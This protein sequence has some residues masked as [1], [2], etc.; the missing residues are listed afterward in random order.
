MW[1]IILND[2]ET[3]TSVEGSRALYVPKKYTGDTMDQFV[4]DNYSRAIDLAM[5]ETVLSPLSG[6]IYV[7][8]LVAHESE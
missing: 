2:G 4:K 5:T 6:D 3:Y 7:R 8:D 1:V